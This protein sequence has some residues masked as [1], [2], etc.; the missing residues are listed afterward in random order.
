MASARASS[1]GRDRRRPGQRL[2][3]Q[4]L[5]PCDLTP[6]STTAGELVD[7]AG[8]HVYRYRGADVTSGVLQTKCANGKQ[9]DFVLVV[10][11]LPTAV[12]EADLDT[13]DAAYDYRVRKVNR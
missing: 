8:N 12:T 4:L 5:S 9:A 13:L 1:L 7:N 11:N 10:S 2:V 3:V 6:G